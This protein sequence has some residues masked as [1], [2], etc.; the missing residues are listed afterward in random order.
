[1]IYGDLS[2]EYYNIVKAHP[3][4]EEISFYQKTLKDIKGTI[5]Y[6]MCGSGRLLIPLLQNGF[7]IEGLDASSHMLNQS[8]RSAEKEGLNPVLYKQS[9]DKISINK[10][11]DMI[12]IVGGSF[13]LIYPRKNVI[14]ALQL[15]KRHLKEGGILLIDTFIPWEF[16]YEDGEREEFRHIV[17]NESGEEIFF[18]RLS[19]ANKSKQL[20]ISQ[21]TY[22]KLIGGKVIKMEKNKMTVLWYHHYE[23]VLLLQSVG[24]KKVKLLKKKLGKNPEL[25]VY[26][27][28]CL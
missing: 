3:F 18:T 7:D 15:V 1:M 28:K 9:I 17:K 2:T 10:K 12:M 19:I 24:Y 6:G 13:Q 20:F 11:Y 26:E 21:N 8:R 27:A 14:K 5:L 16:F 22:Q 23:L 4:P 25:T